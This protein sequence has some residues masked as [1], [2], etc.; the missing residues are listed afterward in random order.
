MREIL[1]K[2]AVVLASM[3]GTAAWILSLFLLSFAWKRIYL[4]L[5]KHQTLSSTSTTCWPCFMTFC[6]PH[7]PSGWAF[8][9]SWGCLSL[10]CC[11]D[12]II[13]WAWMHLGA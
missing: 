4:L 13:P 9:G 10:A 11:M 8:P 12:Y 5:N 1:E 6:K 7:G 2:V 3:L